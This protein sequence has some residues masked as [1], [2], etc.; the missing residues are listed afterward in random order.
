LTLCC[1]VTAS[2]HG[3][4]R[5]IQPED[6]TGP[7]PG[8]QDFE[9]QRDLRA[10]IFL[11]YVGITRILGDLCQYITRKGE[12][13]LEDKRDIASRLNKYLDV[14]P[15]HLCL[16]G[17][18]GLAQSYHLDVAQLHIPILMTISIL[19][20]P[21]SVYQLTAANAGSVTAAFLSF[22]MFQAI[23][24]REHTRFLG[25]PFAWHLLTTAIPLLSS[26]KVMSLRHDANEAL[27]AVE[28]VLDTLGRYR[29]AAANNLRSVKAIRKAMESNANGAITA[30]VASHLA[31]ENDLLVHLG[32]QLLQV[33]GF[34]TIHQFDQIADVLT[35]H[36]RGQAERSAQVA[37]HTLSSLSG[38]QD[39]AMLNNG[40][41]T[42]EMDPFMGI[43]NAQQD[44]QNAFTAV[45]EDDTLS[46]SWMM[47]DWLD[48]LQ[49]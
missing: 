10:E 34:E 45:F 35:E 17:P 39:Q 13:S 26:T 46:T 12:A 29:P 4:P 24:L 48:E 19:F 43:S 28:G 31:E 9:D 22:R 41:L 32:R 20:R 16:Y 44:I 37:A 14:L 7:L 8:L 27:D 3:R 11:Q 15:P 21:P 1:P 33:Y 2:A 25:S 40:Q 30:R 47:K 6:C 36:S 49:M 38:K 18:N 5:I 42:P 23:Q